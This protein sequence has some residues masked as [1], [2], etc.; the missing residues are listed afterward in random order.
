[1]VPS[2]IV[3]NFYIKSQQQASCTSEK[4]CCIVSNFYIK[5]QLRALWMLS[6]ARCI[7]SNFY[8]KSQHP[9]YNDIGYQVVQ[10]PISTSNH[11]VYCKTSSVLGLYS[12]QFLH[13]ITTALRRLPVGRLLYSIQF[14]HQITT[15]RLTRRL[16]RRLYSIQFL[17]Q[18]TTQSRCW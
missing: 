4:C 16:R 13:Q 5:S 14:L 2:C 9:L 18:I 17:H 6:P 3:S 7:V 8:I 1:M 11:N 15:V 10:Y 12:I